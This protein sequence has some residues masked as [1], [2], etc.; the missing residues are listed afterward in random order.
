M[1]LKICELLHLR[2][3]TF[4]QLKKL[5]LILKD[6]ILA[7][8]AHCF[9]HSLNLCISKSCEVPYIKKMMEILGS[10]STFLSA[11]PKRVLVLDTIIS[12]ADAE[13]DQTEISVC[14]KMG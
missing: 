7:H 14:Y 13:K 5:A 2:S 6:A 12:E 4:L 9:N 11:S 1:P 3:T 10:F 8:Y